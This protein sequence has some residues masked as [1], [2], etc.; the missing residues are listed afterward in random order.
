MA[1]PMKVPDHVR[2][3]AAIHPLAHSPMP[4]M[5]DSPTD[6][7]HHRRHGALLIL[8]LLALTLVASVDPATLVARQAAL[9]DPADVALADGASDLSRPIEIDWRVLGTL[10]Y[11]SGRVNDVLRRLDGK[12]VRI[13][14]F[15]VPLDDFA[16]E[17]TEF[18]L[19]PYYGACVHVPPPPP[20][21]MVYVKLAGGKRTRM[22]WWDPVWIE[23]TLNVTMYKSIYG[24]AGFRLTGQR[25]TPYDGPAR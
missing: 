20:N 5:P 15:I 19:V 22:V 8:A 13:P 25:V 17:V 21:Q 4:P 9:A 23:G 3:P 1:L 24:A 11:R 7:S 16:E 12:L 14:G 18:L 6:S 10:D 2:C